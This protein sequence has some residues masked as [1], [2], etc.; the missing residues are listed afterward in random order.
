MICPKC[1]KDDPQNREMCPV[2]GAPVKPIPVPPYGKIQFG[3]YDWYVLDKQNGNALIITEKVL[4][5][6][7][8]HHKIC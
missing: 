6:R 3:K 5:K 2:C 4:E 1:N 8:Y 7:P